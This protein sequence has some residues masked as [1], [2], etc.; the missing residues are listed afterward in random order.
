MSY[1]RLVQDFIDAVVETIKDNGGTDT[2]RTQGA[3]HR[4]L[5]TNFGNSLLFRSGNTQIE[6]NASYGVDANSILQFVE[7]GV[8]NYVRQA[9][10]GVNYDQATTETVSDGYRVSIEKGQEGNIQATSLRMIDDLFRVW[11]SFGSAS[12]EDIELFRASRK[13][14]YNRIVTEYIEVTQEDEAVLID[15][16]DTSKKVVYINLND[17]SASIA[18]FEFTNATENA[19]VLVHF[20][21]TGTTPNG[22]TCVLSQFATFV[23]GGS[24]YD[25]DTGTL[26]LGNNGTLESLILRYARVDEDNQ[27]DPTFAWIADYRIESESTGGGGVE[28]EEE[29]FVEIDNATQAGTTTFDCANANKRTFEHAVFTA[30]RTFE[31]TNVKPLSE[32]TIYIA[33]STGGT[34][35]TMPN[36]IVFN[37]PEWDAQN[38]TLTLE[39]DSVYIIVF[40]RI[41]DTFFAT[42]KFYF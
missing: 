30:S 17:D 32:I 24:R 36:S 8:R 26:T 31:F 9:E 28:V 25:D 18:S 41:R 29:Q 12:E 38:R 37:T 39:Q 16:L 10:N 7:G 4:E 5:L 33:T 35:I 40:K 1:F 42:L 6:N 2:N 19:E 22:T 14:V 15:L 20:N 13:G 34:V 3:K 23:A 21:I 27:G 11:M